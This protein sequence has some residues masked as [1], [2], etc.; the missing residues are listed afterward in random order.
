[1]TIS[2]KLNPARQAAAVLIAGLLLFIR[3]PVPMVYAGFLLFIL[4]MFHQLTGKHT[5]F[6]LFMIF[7]GLFSRSCFALYDCIYNPVFVVP[8]LYSLVFTDLIIKKLKAADAKLLAGIGVYLVLALYAAAGFGSYIPSGIS[9]AAMILPL[10]FFIYVQEDI[11]SIM[12]YAAVPV[13]LYAFLQYFNIMLPADRYW[14]EWAYSGSMSSLYLGSNLRPF[15]VFTSPEEFSRFASIL[16]ILP[17]FRRNRL[18]YAVSGLAALG[19]LAFSY[20]TAIVFTILAYVIYLIAGRKWRILTAAGS[21]LIIFIIIVNIIPAQNIIHKEEKGIS[22][23]LRHITEPVR[24][25]S[26]AYSL[27]RRIGNLKENGLTIVKH[28]FGTGLT[29]NYSLTGHKNNV[30]GSESSFMQL[31]IS[32][33]LPMAAFML[34]AFFMGILKL[35]KCSR[36]TAYIAFSGIFYIFFSHGL[37]LHF[38]TPLFYL[39]ILKVFY[40]NK[41]NN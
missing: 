39:Y 26:G 25:L 16:A 40:G 17:I 6:I 1:M 28:P 38:L 41:Q 23:T 32:A 24:G 18:T 35:R 15:S 7:Y 14:S 31:G 3:T 10:F 12:T 21:L 27:N 34:F 36:E 5:L 37:S 4:V 30:Y 9:F 22:V 13:L 11:I 20:R 19:L 8:A 29:H 33:G 2:G